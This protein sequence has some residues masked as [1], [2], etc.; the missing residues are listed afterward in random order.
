[1]KS[2]LHLTILKPAAS[3]TCRGQNVV[4]YLDTL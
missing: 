3:I 4:D 1:M 2:R